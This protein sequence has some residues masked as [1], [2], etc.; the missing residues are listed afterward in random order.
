MAI[1]NASFETAGTGIGQADEWLW[2]VATVCTCVGFGDNQEEFEEFIWEDFDA[3]LQA[4]AAEFIGGYYEDFA[5]TYFWQSWGSN[6][7]ET[8]EDDFDW[9]TFS[10]TL[11]VSSG[12]GYDDFA[13]VTFNDTM[14]A[15]G[16]VEFN[17]GTGDVTFYES[18]EVRW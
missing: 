17:F 14:I 1:L 18:F 16:N 7:T 10:D 8:F 6:W 15:S 11:V 2:T 9:V 4:L 12:T 5:W 3:T 13:W